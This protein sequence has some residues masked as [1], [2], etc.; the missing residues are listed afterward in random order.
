MTRPPYQALIPIPPEALNARGQ[1]RRVGVELEFSGLELDQITSLVQ[2]VMGGQVQKLSPY[3]ARVLETKIGTVRVEFDTLLFREMKVRNFFKG[4]DMEILGEVERENIE[5]A[6][7]SLAS[8]LVPYELVFPPIPIAQVGVLEELRE[9]MASLAQGTSSSVVNAFGLHLNVEVPE[10]KVDTIL[11]YLRAFLV[12]Y[13]ELKQVHAI[14]PARSLTGFIGPFSKRYALLVLN[15]NYRPSQESFIDDYLTANPTRNRPLDLL[16]ILTEMDEARVRARLPEAKISRRPAF[17][18]RMPNSQI[19]ES[20]WSILREWSAWMRIEKLAANPALLA[21]RA[22]YE[23]RRLQGPYSYWL[24]RLWRTKPLLSRKPMIGVTGPDKGGFPAWACTALAI[25]RAG[26]HPVRLTPAGYRDDPELPP[27]NG[28][29]LGGGA[30]V[31]PVR[32][33]QELQRCFEEE[34]ED[35]SS[36]QR[37]ILSMTLAPILFLWRSIFSLTASGIDKERDEFEQTCLNKAL[38]E[39]LPILGICRGA[40][41]LNIHFGGTLVGDLES[42]YVEVGIVSRVLP[43]KKVHL[44]S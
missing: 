19:D 2:E 44:Q 15:E 3:E 27:I 24:R 32:Y 40:Q 23:T 1:P 43:I 35:E 14:D 11:R 20:D 37:R 4:L 6:L 42:F 39:N 26:G 38:R 36:W 22:R 21:K 12:L 28:L 33:G 8:L 31:D 5:S 9:R 29:V 34:V 17:H 18:Y 13:E 10:L 7:A 41:F 25:R 30:D 16:P